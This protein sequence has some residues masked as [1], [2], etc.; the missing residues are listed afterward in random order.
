MFVDGSRPDVSALFPELPIAAR[1]GWGY[2]LLTNF[3][4]NGGDGT[5]RLHAYADDVEGNTTLLGSKTITCVNSTATAPFGAIDTPA[6][7]E[8]V[9]GSGYPNFG[10][11]LSRGPALAYPPHGTVTVLIDG[12]PA[13]SPGGWASRPD[14]TSLFPA[15]TYDGIG[16]ALGLAAIDTTT[17]ANGLHTIAWIVTANNGQA[18]GIGSRY[19]HVQN[20]TA[21]VVE[22]SVSVEDI[23]AAPQDRSPL[24]ARRGYDL[25]APFRSS[26]VGATGRSTVYGEE[27]DRFEIALGTGQRGSSL[28]GY[29]RSDAALAPLPPGSHLDP[30]TGHFTWQPGVGFLRAYDFVF[31]RHADGGAIARHEVRIVINP[32]GSNRIGAQVT[33]DLP[34]ADS[35]LDSHLP[36]IVTGWA[37]DTSS[38]AGSGV[39]SIHVWAYPTDG[40]QPIFVG[41][42]GTGA[43]PDVA[44]LYGEQFAQS[45]YGLIVEG[46]PPGSYDLA[47]FPWSNIAGGFAPASVRRVTVR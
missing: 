6:Q 11:V 3:L 36:F 7:G 28:S 15:S 20:S 46:L 5:F 17:L 2:L 35:V 19:F 22:A 29:L 9:S 21:P 8:V 25:T 34:A 14:L 37:L 18:A 16:N 23:A 26:P 13:G 47:V 1:S 24:P 31:V 39:G 32:K 42:A 44:A 30:V 38:Y 12:V 40:G 4:P 33:I 27:M 43:R 41:V 10:W 45:G